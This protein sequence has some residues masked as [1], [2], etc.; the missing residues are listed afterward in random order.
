MGP[1][2]WDDKPGGVVWLMGGPVK[3]KD[4]VE[5]GSL[6]RPMVEDQP[7]MEVT[8]SEEGGRGGGVVA[9]G[10]FHSQAKVII[11]YVDYNS[12]WEMVM[13]LK[14]GDLRMARVDLDA[15]YSLM[16]ES[17]VIHE[18]Q[19]A[20]DDWR[21]KGKVWGKQ[22]KA[23]RGYGSGEGSDEY[24]AYLRLPAEVNARYSAAVAKMRPY[25]A[26]IRPRRWIDEVIDAI[27]GFELLDPKVQRRIYKRLAAE[28]FDNKREVD[29]YMRELDAKMGG[30]Q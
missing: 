17:T 1:D 27:K 15:I 6:L 7:Y 28:Y 3:L 8:W 25:K 13:E 24:N 21:S 2:D 19:H 26:K 29:A 30:K 23:W 9:S 20:W 16:K 11:L 5:P 22:D 10:S 12:L 4:F 18:L 14:G